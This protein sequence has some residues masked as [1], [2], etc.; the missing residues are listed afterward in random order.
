MT[1]AYCPEC[2]GLRA[3]DFRFCPKCGF[4]IGRAEAAE[5]MES[6]E[7]RPGIESALPSLTG[8][9]PSLLGTPADA[10]LMLSGRLPD[11]AT[12]SRRGWPKLAGVA[13]AAVAL[14]VAANSGLLTPHHT[15][16]GDFVLRGGSEGTIFLDL[17]CSGIGGYSDIGPGT[18]V[19]VRDGDGKILATSPL[20]VGSQD[21]MACSFTFAL[22][23]VPE[24]AFY[25]F[26]VGRRGALNFSLEE[27]K[28]DEWSVGLSLGQY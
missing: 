17:G 14:L 7:P 11:A 9:S 1:N 19:T 8:V 18:Q 15:V 24:V 16:T 23:D 13:V 2:G 26:E 21:G 6:N 5:G 22:R 10:G 12:G 20:G 4:E 3:G 27:M 28:A 25:S